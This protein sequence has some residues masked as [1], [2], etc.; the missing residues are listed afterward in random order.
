MDINE[1]RLEINSIDDQLL[2][3]FER[4]MKIVREIGLYKKEKALPIRDLERERNV[5]D[6][7]CGKTQ[8]ELGEYVKSLFMNIMELSSTY[9]KTQF[10]L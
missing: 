5:L 9:Q 4:R 6:R 10:T 8:P 1:L 2:G 3:L 7:L